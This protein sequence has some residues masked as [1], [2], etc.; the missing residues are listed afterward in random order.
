VDLPGFDRFDFAKAGTIKPVY[1][2]G[3]GPGVIVM[4]ELPG[5]VPECVRLGEAIAAAG[6]TASLPLFFGSPGQVPASVRSAIKMCLSPEVDLWR[7]GVASPISDRLRGLAR[8]LGSKGPS[9]TIGAIGMCL[10]GS[11]ALAMLLEAEVVA[12]VVS[13]PA[14]PLVHPFS[15]PEERADNGLSAEQL[16][17]AS[18]R[19]AQQDIPVLGFRFEGD[20]FCPKERFAMLRGAFGER[21]RGLELPGNDHSVLTVHFRRLDSADRDRV[22]EALFTFLNQRL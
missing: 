13:Q 14:L 11:F 6:Y 18:E 19:S 9:R 17:G 3:Q 10:A 16:T 20:A 7:R 5:M 8:R 15:R 1:R 4:H 12:P 22:W 2:S 21:F